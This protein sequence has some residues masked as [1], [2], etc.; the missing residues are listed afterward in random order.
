MVGKHTFEYTKQ[1]ACPHNPILLDYNI[2]KTQMHAALKER[3][4][5]EVSEKNVK[6]DKFKKVMK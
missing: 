4:S 2:F 6:L 5:S 3:R 1:F